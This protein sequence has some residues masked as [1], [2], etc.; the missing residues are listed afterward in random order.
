[1]ILV[2]ERPTRAPFGII[3]LDHTVWR[4][5]GRCIARRRQ[6]QDLSELD[7]HLLEDI[8]VTRDAATRECAKP[9]WRR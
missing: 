5:L 7:D 9:F 4:V 2:T 3:G 1:M 8:G 6:R